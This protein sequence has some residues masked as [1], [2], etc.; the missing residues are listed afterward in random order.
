M[1]RKVALVRGNGLSKFE[2]QYYYPLKDKFKLTGICSLNNKFSVYDE[3][4]VIRLPSVYDFEV[5]IPKILKLR[6]IYQRVFYYELFW[7][8]M[9][10]LEKVLKNFDIIHSADIEYYYTY[11]AAK[12]RLKYNSRLVIT[13]WQNIP[14]AY[15]SR[16]YKFV[17]SKRFEIL[18][19]AVDAIIAKSERAKLSLILEGF[20]GEK[21]WVIK[22]GV[23]INKFK[24]MEK[25]EV[26]VK[27][28][29]IGKN[30]KIILFSGRLHWHKGVIVLLNAFKLLLGDKDIDPAKVKLV[31]VGTGE[32][33]KL[34]YDFSKFL[35]IE[36]NVIFAGSVDYDEMPKYHNLADV[37]VLP[38]V[39]TQRWQEQFGMVLIESMACGKPVITTM[40]GSIPEVVE[41]K[42]ILVQ[43][44][45]FLELYKAMKKILIDE[46]LASEMGKKAREF[47][48]QNYNAEDVSKK[49]EKIYDSIL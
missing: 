37:F 1:M 14:F 15:A 33:R 44:F 41:D 29:G 8:K 28:L 48:V 13:Q 35:N 25:P 4:E 22:P 11:Q 42:A 6:K 18:K 39:P 30:D 32:L 20:S 9:F 45:D 40:S 2:L 49:I 26:L 19:K 36:K 34:L 17:E 3:L 16:G 31:L 10:G 21:V 5:L 7:Q 38:S 47:V 43:P 46:K 23:D 12:A 27:K 24:P